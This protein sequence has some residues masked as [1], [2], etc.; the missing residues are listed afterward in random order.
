[1]KAIILAAGMGRRMNGYPEPKSTLKLQGTS[2]IRNSVQMLLEKGIDVAVVI[3]FEGDR[4]K[5]DLKGLNVTYYFN[6]F[7]MNTNSMGSLWFASSFMEPGTDMLI[8]DGDLYWEGQMLEAALED[9][10]RSVIALGDKVKAKNGDYVY[11]T[12]DDM[13]VA[14]GKKLSQEDKDSECVGVMRVKGDAVSA[15]QEA[16][17]RLMKEEKFQT[18]WVELMCDHTGIPVY[19]KDV[20]QFY[21]GEVD[22]E[23]DYKKLLQHFE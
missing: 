13:I 23:D 19:V 7:Y 12:I 17:D 20:S 8:I 14:H 4:I 10:E 2:I 16:M 18:F 21:W 5:E 1:M 15:I 3:G 11:H 6:P 22:F 9:D